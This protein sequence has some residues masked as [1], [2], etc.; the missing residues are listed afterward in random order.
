MAMIRGI[1][2]VTIALLQTTAAAGFSRVGLSRI[3]SLS[4]PHSPPWLTVRGGA[5]PATL[6][7]SFIGSVDT[8]YKSMPLA[9]AFL[10]VCLS[11]WYII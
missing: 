11:L 3:S 4:V 6:K 7:S 2:Y 9:S 10:T 1:V 8:F 5:D